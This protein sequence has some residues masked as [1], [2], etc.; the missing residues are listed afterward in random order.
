MSNLG[1]ILAVIIAIAI[2][3][4]SSFFAWKIGQNEGYSKGYNALH[5]TDTI[6]VADTH[7]VDRPIEVIK[8]KEKDHPIY[9]AVTDTMKIHDTTFVVLPR[10]VKIYEDSTYTARVSGVEPSLDWIKVYQ[11]TAYVTNYIEKKE[12]YKN[13]L[14]FYGDV[15]LPFS[16]Q[17]G[18]GYEGTIWGPLRYTLR[19]GYD[20]KTKWYMGAGLK[21][22]VRHDF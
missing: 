2:V 16:A 19:T 9:I 17:A 20:Y 14:Y 5:P 3:F 22:I 8:W 21:I 10:E 7:Y 13:E 11:K 4:L 18:L 15:S 6:W 12:P 1:R